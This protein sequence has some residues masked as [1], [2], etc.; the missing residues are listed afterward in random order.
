MSLSP[1]PAKCLS[2]RLFSPPTPSSWCTIIPPG[3]YRIQ[4]YTAYEA[5]SPVKAA[6]SALMDAA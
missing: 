1:I 6:L 5:D 4:F 2:L 3:L